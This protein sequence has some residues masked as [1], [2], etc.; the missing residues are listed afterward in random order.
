MITQFF[1]SISPSN[2]F[3]L[4]ALTITLSICQMIFGSIE[5]IDQSY[6]P[7]GE[8]VFT[9]F[10]V[11]KLPN[12]LNTLLASILICFQ[13]LLLNK[14]CVKQAVL[15][16]STY[17][18]GFFY[19]IAAHCIPHFL[20]LN[21][22]LLVNFLIIL[23]FNNIFKLNKTNRGLRLAFD[24]GFLIGTCTL[25]YIPSILLTI[26]VVYS[27]LIIKSVDLRTIITAL[28][29][30]LV[31]LLWFF[32]LAYLLDNPLLTS[33]YINSFIFFDGGLDFTDF[34]WGL[35]IPALSFSLLLT[36]SIIKHLATSGQQMIVTRKFI[37]QL[38]LWLILLC[39]ALIIQ[40]PNILFHFQLA[41]VP[42][43]ILVANYYSNNTST[44]LNEFSV[45]FIALSIVI[46]QVF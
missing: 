4:F 25:F 6:S 12:W 15:S 22:I 10:G 23:L 17:L 28:A 30:V 8:F 13:A 43:A 18:V 16:K 29:G 7:F 39:V 2:V 9:Y 14:I 45:A 37:Q 1:R 20:T 11:E 24:F 3:V 38:L 44:R 33:N 46:S 27:Y 34:S 19:I 21:P 36:F 40:L 32:S 42:S 5:T 31:P 35:L 26:V 41:L